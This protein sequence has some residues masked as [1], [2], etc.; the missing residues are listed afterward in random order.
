MEFIDGLISG[1]K[2]SKEIHKLIEEYGYRTTVQELLNS[3]AISVKSLDDVQHL[4]SDEA[5]PTHLTRA[6]VYS[7]AILQTLTD[8]KSW[9]LFRLP[10]TF[11]LNEKQIEE[12]N[13]KNTKT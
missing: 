10:K 12:I 9:N 13:A 1:W 8:V 6:G 3:G 2:S 4:L 5:N 11:V 7:G